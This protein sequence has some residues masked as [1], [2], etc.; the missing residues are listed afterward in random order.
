[1]PEAKTLLR[2]EKTAFNAGVPAPPRWAEPESAPP[3]DDAASFDEPQAG[4][5]RYEV[6]ALLGEG[7]MGQVHLCRD[8]LI[9]RE[10]ALKMM[11]PEFEGQPHVRARFLR[12]AR[13]QGQLEHPGIVPVHDIGVSPD[14]AT[15]FTMKRVRGTTLASVIEALAAGDP[16]AEARFSLRRLLAAFVSVC[17]AVDFAHGR[18]VL[19]RDL[20]PGNIMLGTYGEVSVLDWGLA[21][22][23]GEA[24]SV[25]PSSLSRVTDQSVGALPPEAHTA[26][27]ALLGT[28]GYMAPEYVL[29]AQAT[30]QGDV[31]ALGAILFEILALEP[32]YPRLSM[33]NLVSAMIDGADPR[34]SAR[35]PARPV[36]PELEAI[37]VRATAR[38][39]VDRYKTARELSE[40]VERFLEGDRDLIR[41]REQ[42]QA[43]AD[44]A[45][46][47]I[48]GPGG[49]TEAAR[50]RAM[51]DLG[52]ALA[53]DPE[54][55]AARATLIRVLT[56]PPDAVPA[57]VTAAMEAGAQTQLRMGASLGSRVMMVWFLFLPLFWWM[58]MRD[59]TVIV[60]VLGPIGIAVT[61]SL[62]ES[63]RAVVRPWVQYVNIVC[64]TLGIAATSRIF[65]PFMLMPLLAATYAL[66]MQ[67]HPHVAPRKVTVALC[68]LAM[69]APILL[70]AAGILP[71]TITVQEGAIVIRT[72]GVLR[73]GPVIAFLAIAGVAGTLAASFFIAQLRDA[74]SRTERRVHLHAWHVQRMVPEGLPIRAQMMKSIPRMPKIQR[75]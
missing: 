21:K 31:F 14:G 24:Q 2:V 68:C 70:E 49:A 64:T 73:E 35:C 50:T 62:L 10:V 23:E 71:R 45:A 19:H 66:S 37:C 26:L 65:G 3:V 5:F 16:E 48:A 52:H 60:S 20:K 38:L 58:G 54:N 4:A 25:V 41:R 27:G 53:L 33:R 44:A 30:A 9:G 72:L 7:G 17:L 42:A 43:H 69:V 22:P 39:R 28:P 51:R 29:E 56:E 12:E 36:A 61:L 55:T 47:E 46:A 13:V 57:E 63:R 1:V 11:L 34:L 15:Y 8:A 40:A 74:L 75:F 67:V 32:L 18:G 6:K 59:V